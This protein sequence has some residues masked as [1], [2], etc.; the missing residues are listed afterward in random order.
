MTTADKALTILLRTIGVIMLFALV[1]V[2]TPM[3]WMVG[4][5]RWLGL[6]EMPSDPVVE[7]LARCVSAFYAF[8][9]VLCLGL[10][11]DPQR[12]RP[13]VLLLGI[14]LTVFG[15][16]L[17]G[18]DLAAHMPWWWAISEGPTTIVFGILIAALARRG[19]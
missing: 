14:L 2:L 4:T 9:G 8:V 6:G 19:A 1:A 15:V 10:A 13:L 3:S 12:Y 17:I 11:A 5:H 7:Y 18:I 16:V